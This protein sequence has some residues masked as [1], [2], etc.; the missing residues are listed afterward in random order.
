MF[1]WPDPPE[2]HIIV[3]LPFAL[4]WGISAALAIVL[5]AIMLYLAYNKAD[6]QKHH[7]IRPKLMV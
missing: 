1:K 6:R 2:G 3:T 4:Y 5:G 7:S